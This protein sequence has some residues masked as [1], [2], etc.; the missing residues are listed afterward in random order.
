LQQKF[1]PSRILYVVSANHAINDGSTAL[2]A[3]LFPVLFLDLKFPL[4]QIGIIVAVGYLMNVVCQPIAGHYSERFEPRIL[5]SLG[6][7]LI[8]A[9]MFV[10]AVSSGFA[11]ILA[12]VVVLRVGSSV[13]HP[14]GASA[15]SR[16]FAASRLDGPMGFESAFGN[17]GILLVFLVS[18]PLYIFLGWRSLFLVFATVDLLVVAV[19]LVALRG[20]R[21]V[22]GNSE[23]KDET[24]PG[25]DGGGVRRGGLERV[26]GLPLFFI[27]TMLISGGSYAVVVNYGNSLLAQHNFGILEANLIISAWIGSAFIG[28]LVTGRLTRVVSRLKLLTASY[29]VAAVSI[30]VFALFPGASAVALGSLVV[31]GFFLSASYPMIYSELSAFLGGR[32]GSRRGPLFGLLF[33]AQIIGSVILGFLGGYL[34]EFF[35]LT[36]SFELV[37][38]LLIFGSVA[39]LDWMRSSGGY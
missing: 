22:S 14:V 29:S 36:F 13:F 25:K 11:S 7:A 17:L 33:S 35:P 5:L 37:A 32:S 21:L 30:L 28:A 1:G 3:T 39:S 8:A 6:I 18:A 24:A 26:V 16:A 4:F 19:T 31:N 20:S 12:S 38:V 27:A 15:V 34:A 23:S 9:S 2:I 10:F